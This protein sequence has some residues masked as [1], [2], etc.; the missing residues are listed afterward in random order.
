[1][2]PTNPEAV[3]ALAV[4]RTFLGGIKACSPT[5]MRSVIFPGGHATLIR[6]QPD[7]TKTIL[8]ITLE[9]AVDRIPFDS[10]EEL[11]EAIASA[12]WEESRGRLF[13]LLRSLN[14]KLK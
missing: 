4:C 7:G 9:Q 1:M 5:Q 14:P 12:E 10:P 2:S 3:A 11:E 13:F 6:P 8:Q